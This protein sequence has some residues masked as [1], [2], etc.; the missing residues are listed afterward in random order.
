MVIP[1]HRTG[2]DAREDTGLNALKWGTFSESQQNQRMNYILAYNCICLLDIWLM[3][4][5][6]IHLIKS[7]VIICS[8]CKYCYILV[9]RI[10]GVC[11]LLCLLLRGFTFHTCIILL[12]KENPSEVLVFS[13]GTLHS[14]SPIRYTHSAYTCIWE[15]S[16]VTSYCVGADRLSSSDMWDVWSVRYGQ[17]VRL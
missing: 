4:M 13:P 6:Q 5:W 7:P 11:M 8:H 3:A 9:K 10:L 2:R 12:S 14:W 15:L 16:L 1:C 17:L